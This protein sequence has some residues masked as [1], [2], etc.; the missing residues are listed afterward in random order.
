MGDRLGADDRRGPGAVLDDD[1]LAE[2]LGH[3]AADEAREIVGSATRRIRHHHPD[4]PI[5]IGRLGEAVGADERERRSAGEHATAVTVHGFPPGEP[6]TLAT[7]RG[8][9]STQV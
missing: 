4:R 3:G 1:G 2:R 8:A 6:A 5:R 9:G 7:L